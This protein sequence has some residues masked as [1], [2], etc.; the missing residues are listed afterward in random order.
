M[1][2]ATLQPIYDWLSSMPTGEWMRTVPWAWPLCESI[3]F[4]GLSLLAGTVGLFD[5][6]LLGFARAV[7][8]AA[9]HRLIP[10]GVGGFLMNVAT[11]FCFLTGTPDQ[12]LLNSAFQFKVMFLVIAG[13]NMGAFYLTMFRKV[14]ALGPGDQAPLP[15]RVIGGV[16]LAA[17]I[18]VMTCGRLLTFFRPIL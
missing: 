8:M 18:G 12:Y 13:L 7:P 5:L 2:R 15:A 16:S 9:F 17:W 11:G 6:R 3:H 4:I 1:D 14:R 10:I